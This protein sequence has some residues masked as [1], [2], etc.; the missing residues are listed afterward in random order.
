MDGLSNLLVESEAL[1]ETIKSPSNLDVN[2]IESKDYSKTQ[3]KLMLMDLIKA[4][5]AS[6]QHNA[7]INKSTVN[8][9]NE[10]S[11]N[12]QTKI[13]HVTPVIPSTVKTQ[14][15]NSGDVKPMTKNNNYLI[16]SGM[17]PMY[18]IVDN[19]TNLMDTNKK[20]REEEDKNRLR[21]KYNNKYRYLNMT[22]KVISTQ[23]VNNAIDNVQNNNK[24]PNDENNVRIYVVSNDNG[25]VPDCKVV[26]RPIR[27]LQQR[28]LTKKFDN[29]SMEPE[30]RKYIL[31]Y[32]NVYQYN[33]NCF[34]F[35][36]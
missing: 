21:R 14:Y 24:L 20:K 36:I 1:L 8:P 35:M 17:V 10:R 15:K 34:F 12:S 27:P 22:K 19:D 25:N 16:N 29:H 30:I 26:L 4:V 7:D 6:E 28:V 13:S 3:I 11:T 31:I 5:E 23:N 18:N 9:T 33:L 32:T 2:R